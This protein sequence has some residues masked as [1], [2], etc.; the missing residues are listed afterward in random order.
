MHLVRICSH[1]HVC[2]VL[3]LQKFTSEEAAERATRLSKM[4][5]LLFYAEQ[6]AKRLSKIKSKEYHR[7]AGGHTPPTC[8]QSRAHHNMVVLK[9]QCPQPG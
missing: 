2:F 1:A 6:K 8:Q 7:Y 4:R 3:V 9:L 5:H